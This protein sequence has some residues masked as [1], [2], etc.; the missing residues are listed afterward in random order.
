[1]YIDTI[2]MGRGYVVPM[3]IDTIT[4]SICIYIIVCVVLHKRHQA[5]NRHLLGVWEVGK[6]SIYTCTGI[7]IIGGVR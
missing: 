7:C 1:M 3:Y 5:R 2:N 4:V 6:I